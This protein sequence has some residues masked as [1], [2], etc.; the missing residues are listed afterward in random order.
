ME[1][2]IVKKTN[3]GMSGKTLEKAIKVVDRADELKSEGKSDEAFEL[4][5]TL[6]KSVD[7]ASRSVPSPPKAEPKKKA[8]PKFNRTNDNIKWAKW[9]WNPVTGCEHGCEYCYAEEIS[10]RF[11]GHFKPEFH[12]ARLVAPD[13]TKPDSSIPGG[14][15]V[16]VCSMA[17][18]FGSWVP[19]DWIWPVIKK[20][21]EHP[22]WTFLFLTKNPRRYESVQFPDNAWIGATVDTQARVKPTLDAFEKSSATVKFVSCEPL[23]EP[24]VFDNMDAIDWV[25]IGSQSG[26]NNVKAFQPEFEWVEALHNQARSYDIPVYWK[27]NLKCKPEEYPQ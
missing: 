15:A 27:D 9:T 24:V 13:N 22:E 16:F 18:L 26:T 19:N 1:Y 17:D 12:E 2:R 8:P 14:N 23:L 10:M 3:V 4:I 20:V 7:K 11:N 5:S 25:I 21:E 6:N